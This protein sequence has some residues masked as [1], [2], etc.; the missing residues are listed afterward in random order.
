MA[1]TNPSPVSNAVNTALHPKL[2]HEFYFLPSRV[3]EALNIPDFGPEKS[4]Q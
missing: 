3:G 1:G 4:P 2:V